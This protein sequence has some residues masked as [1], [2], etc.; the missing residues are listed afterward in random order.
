MLAKI[1]RAGL[2]P[3]L[4]GWMVAASAESVDGPSM[5]GSSIEVVQPTV[6][7]V[8]TAAPGFAPPPLQDYVIGPH[9]LLEISVFRVDELSRTVRVNSRGLISLPM[10]GA[11]Q[12]AGATAAA[13]EGEIA[14]R[15][16]ECCL[17]DPQVSI[18]I[19]EFVSQRVT[20]E[21]EVEKP[22]VYALTGR[23]T[24]LQTIAM[25]AGVGELADLGDVRVFRGQQD[26]STEQLLYDVRAIREGTQPDPLIQGNDI[27]VVSRSGGLSVVKSVTDTLR[28]FIGFGTVR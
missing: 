3:V 9:D 4:L 15:L 28:G 26:G 20:V 11:V 1:L 17:Q 25:A 10:I 22:G 6:Q 8:T 13:V 24:L 5:E 14:A 12:A 23:T 2:V 19:K 7:P 27:V 18:F 21:G 16:L